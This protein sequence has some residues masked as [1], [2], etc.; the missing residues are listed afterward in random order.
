MYAIRSYY[1]SPFYWNLSLQN[2]GVAQGQ[3]APDSS[4][5]M[6]YGPGCTAVPYYRSDGCDD[7]SDYRWRTANYSYNFV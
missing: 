7:P 4:G 5:Y 3:P 2:P 1:G 6:H